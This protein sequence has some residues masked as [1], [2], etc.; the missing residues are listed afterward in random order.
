MVP[1]ARRHFGRNFFYQHDNAPPHRA[2]RIQQYLEQEAVQQLPWPAVSPDLNPIEH[3]WSALG[4]AVR[5]GPI[6]PTNL[7]ELEDALVQQWVALRQRDLNELIES[8]ASHTD[9][10]N[11]A[12][13]GYTRY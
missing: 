9:A 5:K 2:R 7:R 8:V 10:V 3:A 12:R 13:G 1:Y 6:R 4:R 11:Q